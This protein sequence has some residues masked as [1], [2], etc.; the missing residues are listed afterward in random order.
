MAGLDEVPVRVISADD[1]RVAELALV[2]N[3]QREDLNP[4]EEAHGYK[5]LMEEYGLTQEEA[6]DKYGFDEKQ[7]EQLFEL[8]SD[9]NKEMWETLL[10]G[11]S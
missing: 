8:L 6:A 1:R 7:R 4:I 9:K 3:L 2:E 10:P 5:T 11:L